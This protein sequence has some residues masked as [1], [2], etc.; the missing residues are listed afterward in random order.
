[1]DES[2][3]KGDLKSDENSPRPVRIWDPATRLFHWALV[4]LVAA[5]I[6]TGLVGGLWEMDLHMLS[7]YAILSLVVFRVSWGLVGSRHS[8][9]SDFVRGPGAV[10]SYV[11]RLRRGDDVPAGGHN[12]LGGWSVMA[13]LASLLVQATT[14]LFANDDIFTEGPLA[15]TVS[16]ATS[17]T[18]TWI[19]HVNSNV[20]YV[21]IAVHLLAVLGYL[22]VKRDNLI[23]PMFTGR[24]TVPP[25]TTTN[26][27]PFANPWRA[28]VLFACAAAL[29]WALVGR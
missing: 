28:V 6:Y 22:I 13:M 29:V 10:I 2:T 18:L 12:P 16:K 14:G 7:G 5:N 19:H 23:R 15:R 4:I 17:D 20:L 9:F 21:L 24:K 27:A 1:M 11:K 3:I 25:G 26:D 8:R